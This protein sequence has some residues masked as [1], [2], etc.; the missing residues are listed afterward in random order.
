MNGEKGDDLPDVTVLMAELDAAYATKAD[1][2]R[3]IAALGLT[4]EGLETENERLRAV[5]DD[6]TIAAQYES[7]IGTLNAAIAGLERMLA[8][9]DAEN[10]RLRA[11][12]E[13]A[14]HLMAWQG[15]AKEDAAFQALGISLSRLDISGNIGGR[16]DD[17]QPSEDMQAGVLSGDAVDEAPLLEDE[18]AGVAIGAD[19][20]PGTRT[21]PASEDGEVEPGVA[22][23][24]APEDDTPQFRD[25][26]DPGPR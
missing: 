22:A 3:M 1:D 7:H 6:R 15:T 11:V 4:V 24:A 5:D 16:G 14:E 12:V 9:A 19:D 13:A 23:G 2:D 8:E 18:P 21:A 26:F 10:A 17:E 20:R 25:P